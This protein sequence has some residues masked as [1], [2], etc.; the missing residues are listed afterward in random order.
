MVTSSPTEFSLPSPEATSFPN[1]SFSEHAWKKTAAPQLFSTL[2]GSVDDGGVCH[3]SVLLPA[4]AFPAQRV[5]MLEAQSHL[6]L[7]RYDREFSKVKEYME[8]IDGLGQQLLNLT[9]RVEHMSKSLV[10]YS[11]LDFELLKLEIQEMER[12][13]VELKASMGDSN[14][15]VQQ[16]Y[17]EIKNMSLMVTHL[18]SLD[19]NNL[20]AI[21]REIVTLKQRLKDCEEAGAGQ[22]VEPGSCKHGGLVNISKPYPVEWNWRGSGYPYG[23]WGKDYFPGNPAKEI[24]WVTAL[25]DAKLMQHIYLYSSYDNLLLYRPSKTLAYWYGQGSGA[26]MYKN[27]LYFN[28]YDTNH[29]YK[30]DVNTNSVLMKKGIPGA[31]YAN[32][33]SYAGVSWQDIDLAVDETS[34]WAIY[35]TESNTGNIVISKLNETTLEVQKTWT[36]RQYKP[37]ASSAFIACGVLYVTRSMNTIQEEVFYTFDT[38]TGKEGRTSITFSKPFRTIQGVNYHPADHKLYVYNDGFLMMYDL[39]FQALPSP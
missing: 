24:Y 16:L 35:S 21:R 14:V 17:V 27:A 37:S 6:L 39:E 34:L 7:K 33:F 36:T 15:V 8:V 22:Q 4:D 9:Q 10:S 31:V 3:C 30:Y 23:V 38:N 11:E 28:Q 5:E 18:E 12:L 29:V 19:K 20:L 13:V 26:T 1:A 25:D 32:R 2:E